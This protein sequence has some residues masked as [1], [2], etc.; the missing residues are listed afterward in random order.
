[1]NTVFGKV[2]FT[3]MLMRIFNLIH[4]RIHQCDDFLW[5]IAMPQLNI[6]LGQIQI[7]LLSYTAG[8]NDIS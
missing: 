2:Y 5:S 1:M 3:E 4:L 6:V 7:D 8:I